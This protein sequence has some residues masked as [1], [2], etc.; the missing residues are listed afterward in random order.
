[1]KRV[2]VQSKGLKGKGAMGVIKVLVGE[3]LPLLRAGVCLAVQNAPDLELVGDTDNADDLVKLV[4][5]YMPDSVIIA[6]IGLPGFGQ[7]GLITRIKKICPTCG[8]LLLADIIDLSHVVKCGSAGAAGYVKK[9]ISLDQLC[10]AVRS[11]YGGDAIMDLAIIREAASLLTAKGSVSY[12]PNILSSREFEI[13]RLASKGLR[14]KTIAEQLSISPRTVHNY[15]RSM[16][17]KMGIGSRT[18]AIYHASRNGWITL[19]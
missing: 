6:D 5:E 12:V 17:A 14:N 7:Q 9:N 16:F 8:I 18:E 4:A 1:M 13:L 10:C 3:H 2:L 11:I 19:D 15:F